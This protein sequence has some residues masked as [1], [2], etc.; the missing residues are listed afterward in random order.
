MGV[1]GQLNGPAALPLQGKIPR[2]PLDRRLG[3][4]PILCGRSGEKKIPQPLQTETKF[5]RTNGQTQ[6][7]H[8]AF[9]VYTL[10]EGRVLNVQIGNYLE[11]V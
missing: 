11:P 1:S 9:S 6:R 7:H 8:F 4:P 5:S 10:Q 2:Y 3:G